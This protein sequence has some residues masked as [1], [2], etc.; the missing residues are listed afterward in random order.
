VTVLADDCNYYSDVVRLATGV[1]HVKC[2]SSCTAVRRHP[3]LVNTVVKSNL[4][5]VKG[6][7]S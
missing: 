1:H 2:L 5:Q 3:M 6:A 7:G 4:Q